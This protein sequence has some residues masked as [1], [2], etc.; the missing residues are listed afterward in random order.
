MRDLCR[1][2]HCSAQ[3]GKRLFLSDFYDGNPCIQS[4]NLITKQLSTLVA[5]RGDLSQVSCF[6]FDR[7]ERYPFESMLYFLSDGSEICSID[8]RTGTGKPR[9][10]PCNSGE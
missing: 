4:V 10:T 9:A 3:D 6:L 1:S 2:M 7:S 8:V 5:L